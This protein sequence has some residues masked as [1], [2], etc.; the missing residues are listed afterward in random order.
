MKSAEIALDLWICSFPL[1]LCIAESFAVKYHNSSSS[2]S[3]SLIGGR[4]DHTF[5]E[6]GRPFGTKK[7]ISLQT[8][9]SISHWWEHDVFPPSTTFSPV[10]GGKK[11]ETCQHNFHSDPTAYREERER[12]R[13]RAR[14]HFV[15]TLPSILATITLDWNRIVNS[16]MPFF[17]FPTLRRTPNDAILLRIKRENPHIIPSR[18]IKDQHSLL[19]TSQFPLYWQMKVCS[20]TIVRRKKVLLQSKGLLYL[21]WSK[22]ARCSERSKGYKISLNYNSFSNLPSIHRNLALFPKC[23]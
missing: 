11:Y 18:S 13:E 14:V 4:F 22:W 1:F 2:L 23:K 5:V 20:E 3:L 12:E 17:A 16:R 9:L 21:A 10:G 15:L 6:R 8:S 7:R 19:L